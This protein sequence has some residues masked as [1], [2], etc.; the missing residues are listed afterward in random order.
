MFV[1]T[2]HAAD[3]LF[4]EKL[5]H[6]LKHGDAFESIE[7]RGQALWC[8]AKHVDSQ[9]YYRV[10]KDPQGKKFWV[11]LYSPDR[12]LSESIEAD[13]MHAGDH[14]EELLEEELFELGIKTQLP[15]EHFRDDN[16]QYVFRSPVTLPGDPAKHQD[17]DADWLAKV[18]LAYEATFR[19]L[20][21]M[22]PSEE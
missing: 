8:R 11:G 20:G 14:I 13:L 17:A 22:K 12:W 2:T 21:N 10:T 3:P 1:V 4:F 9:T 6:R 15:V 18:L 19:Q 5:A 16:K 7:P